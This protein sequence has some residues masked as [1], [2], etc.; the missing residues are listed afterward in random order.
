[1]MLKLDDVKLGTILQPADPN[2]F[3]WDVSGNRKVW[4]SK[5]R[6]YV[7]QGNNEFRYTDIFGDAYHQNYMSYLERCWS[8]HLIAVIT[9]DIIW[10]TIL[11]ELTLLVKENVETY[12]PLFTDSGEKKTITVLTGDPVVIPLSSLIE[13]LRDL[14]PTNIDMF[15]PRFSTSNE[16]STLAK[17]AAFC[18]MVSPYYDYCMKLCGIPFVRIDGTKEDYEELLNSWNKIYGTLTNIKSND[19]KMFSW[20][21]KVTSLLSNILANLD[22]ADFWKKMFYLDKCGSGGDKVVCGWWK[23]FYRVQPS[24]AYPHNFST[25]ISDVSYKF[26]DTGQDFIMK[27]GLLYS[28]LEDDGLLVPEFGRIVYEKLKQQ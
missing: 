23:D 13:K 25:H 5:E 2:L 19:F 20:A 3:I 22:N 12:R 1:M 4:D 26:L 14:V 11:C 8:D 9:P 6:K 17:Y 18:D 21:T 16:R 10:Y 27:S 15:L 28:K 24:P 7:A